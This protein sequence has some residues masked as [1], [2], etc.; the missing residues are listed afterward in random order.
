MVLRDPEDVAVSQPQPMLSEVARGCSHINGLNIAYGHGAAGGEQVSFF[1]FFEGWFFEPSEIALDDFVRWA[2]ACHTEAAGPQGHG[3]RRKRSRMNTRYAQHLQFF[4]YYVRA[5]RREFFLRRGVP[6]SEM[7]NASY[8]V[9]LV[10]WVRHLDDP[11]VLVV[12]FEDLKEDLPAHVRRIAA[13]MGYKVR[14]RGAGLG[15]RKE[16]A[17]PSR[18]RAFDGVCE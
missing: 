10:S 14:G 18:T 5:P 9:H 6:A 4:I 3:S 7:Q 16:S 1:R 15:S 11:D 8:W 13:F 12:F 17:R 2:V